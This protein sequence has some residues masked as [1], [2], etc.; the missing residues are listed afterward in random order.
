MFSFVPPNLIILKPLKETATVGSTFKVEVNVS[1]GT[2]NVAS[3]F[4]VTVVD[5]YLPYFEESL[6]H[7]LVNA[8]MASSYD[9]PDIFDQDMETVEAVP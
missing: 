7:Q 4:N 2:H 1:D 6:K 5:N 8:G 9:L 3:H